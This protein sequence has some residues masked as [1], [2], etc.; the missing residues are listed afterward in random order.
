[1]NCNPCYS[2]QGRSKQKF[3]YG[4]SANFAL[5][6]QIPTGIQVNML[7]IFNYRMRKP[8]ILGIV[9]VSHCITFTLSNLNEIKKAL[10]QH[11][12]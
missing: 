7:I 5:L 8:S 11:K 2:L 4:R 6:P 3:Y 10:L 12:E 1:M 9:I